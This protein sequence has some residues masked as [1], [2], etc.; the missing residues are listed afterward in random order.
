[1]T[2]TNQQPSEAEVK[3][4]IALFSNGEYQHTLVNMVSQYDISNNPVRVQMV[5]VSG[6]IFADSKHPADTDVTST[7]NIYN[8]PEIAQAILVGVGGMARCSRDEKILNICI[9]T[10]NKWGTVVLTRLIMEVPQP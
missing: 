3:S 1:M 2:N 6:A 4:V 9:G 7:S 8:N 5:T 10:E